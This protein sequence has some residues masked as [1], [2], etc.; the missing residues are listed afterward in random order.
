MTQL[1][2]LEEAGIPIVTALTQCHKQLISSAEIALGDYDGWLRR[3]EKIDAN[4]LETIIDRWWWPG[5]GGAGKPNLPPTW[6]SLLD[7]LKKLNKEELGQQIDK[8]LKK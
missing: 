7:V 3:Y 2:L 6:R 5:R 4:G 8:Y 1:S